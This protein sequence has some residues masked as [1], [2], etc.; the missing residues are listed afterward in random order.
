MQEPL[1][2]LIEQEK[3]EEERLLAEAVKHSCELR[4]ND[5]LEAMQTLLHEETNRFKLYD[6]NREETAR[7]ILAQ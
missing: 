3:L 4:R 1:S 6:Q 7:S 2:Q 5:V